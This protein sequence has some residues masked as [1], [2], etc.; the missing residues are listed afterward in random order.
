MGAAPCFSDGRGEV[1]DRERFGEISR[2]ALLFNGKFRPS[3]HIGREG[4][5]KLTKQTIRQQRVLMPH[6]NT[7]GVLV[8]QLEGNW[9]RERHL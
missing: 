7:L 6:Y 2:E 9:I 3:V 1:R 8:D 5:D 4:D